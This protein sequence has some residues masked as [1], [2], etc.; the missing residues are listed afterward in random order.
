[1]NTR[2]G[3]IGAGAVAQHHLRVLTS[4]DDVTV[5]ALANRNPERRRETAEAFSIPATYETHEEMLEQESLDALLVLTSAD[6]I[7]S[8]TKSLIPRGLPLLIEKPAGRTTSETRELAVLARQSGTRVM[9]G[10]NRRFYSV[11]NA[12]R[13][14]IEERGSLRGIAIEAPERI[15]A[16]RALGKF[17]ESLIEDWLVLNG[18]HGVDLLRFLGGDVTAAHAF[19]QSFQEKRGDNFGAV[20]SYTNGAIGHYLSHWNSPGRWQLT[21]YGAGVRARL[22]PIEQGTLLIGEDA[23]ILPVDPV[24]IEYKP[25]FYAQARY[26]VD[27]VKDGGAIE[28]PACSIDDAVGTMELTELISGRSS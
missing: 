11:I 19:H 5:S 28:R 6:T 27:R 7:H 4:F 1:M 22:E 2:I 25:G 23:S 12:A 8:I 18:T 26:F 13:H 17:P 24:D 20:L 16:V 21:L 9:V 3:I 14:A 10:Y 15:D